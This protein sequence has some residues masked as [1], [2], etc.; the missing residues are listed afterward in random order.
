MTSIGERAFS[1][2]KKLWKV[3]FKGSKTKKIGKKAFSGTAS[4]VTL[5]AK[6]ADRKRYQ[7]LL[8]KAGVKKVVVKK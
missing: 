3:T 4:K 2:C 6:K 1:G 8:R 5:V 7:K